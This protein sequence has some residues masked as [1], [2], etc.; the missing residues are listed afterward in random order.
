MLRQILRFPASSLLTVLIVGLILTSPTRAMQ[1][2]RTPQQ[3]RAEDAEGEIESHYKQGTESYE[4]AFGEFEKNASLDQPFHYDL[5]FLADY[6]QT[7]VRTGATPAARQLAAVYLS[8]LKDYDVL[9]PEDTYVE[10]ARL[11][12]PGSAL[13]NRAPDSIRFMSE[14]LSSESA[15]TFL[16]DLVSRNPDRPIQARALINL[17]KLASRQHDMVNYRHSYDQLASHYE[18]LKD[19]AFDIKLLNPDNKTA[20]GKKAAT[21]TL[22]SV[23]SAKPFSNQSL[24]GRYYLLDFWATWCGPCRGERAALSRAYERFKGRNFTIVSISL[25]E[26]AE[27]VKRF[28]ETRWA[29]PWEN[30]ILPG[31]QKSQTGA[32][33][34]VSWLGLPHLVLVG[35]DGTIL[36]IR[37]QL[38]GQ[39]L[40]KTL[41]EYLGP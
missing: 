38:S 10:V 16:K 2:S 7:Q 13:W 14:G 23:E 24:S 4:K 11:V 33:Y 40:Q 22:P 39:A 35:P 1:I 20:I 26:K 17:A 34:D 9:L 12:S 28:R 15:R 36:A 19:L 31:G 8:T 3:A 27:T 5:S 25:D 30:L 29:M 41:A 21:F 37:D 18:D 6:L 32:N